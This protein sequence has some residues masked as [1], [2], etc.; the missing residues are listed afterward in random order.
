MAVSNFEERAESERNS[1][2][3]NFDLGIGVIRV[4]KCASS[5]AVHTL[6]A[7]SRISL[8]EA[9][10]D[11][12]FLVAAV[13]DPV[14]R[15]LSSIPETLFRSTPD[16]SVFSGDIVVSTSEYEEIL[17]LGGGTPLELAR[18]IFKKIA[19]EGFFEIH[20]LPM[21][22]FFFEPSGEV[23][24][25]LHIYRSDQSR[26]ALAAILRSHGVNPGIS[27]AKTRINRRHIDTGFVQAP[28]A[29]EIKKRLARIR[30]RLSPV[31]SR[32]YPAQHPILRLVD[33]PS[34][35]SSFDLGEALKRVYR[36]IRS[37]P[38]LA[39]EARKLVSTKYADD[40]RLFEAVCRSRD[41]LVAAESISFD[42]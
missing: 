42:R 23:R 19:T 12:L 40:S 10:S 30:S 13:R 29:M 14:E 15:L 31:Y 37:D 24:C 5:T 26:Q 6:K 33:A 41:P 8:D 22:P 18:A 28:V 32:H 16:P 3:A 1:V 11:G 34:P 35:I 39:A 20:H 25:A 21:F 38:Q 7:Y 4:P 17:G 2:H 9:V 27:R 36:E